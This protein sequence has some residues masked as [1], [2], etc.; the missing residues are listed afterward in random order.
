MLT[1]FGFENPWWS[2]PDTLDRLLDGKRDRAYLPLFLDLV[3]KT[4]V[5]RAVV[6]MGPRRVGKTILLRQTIRALIQD[7]CV[8][9]KA[10]FFAS[11]ENPIYRGWSLDRIL[12]IFMRDR[13]LDRFA[14]FWAVFDEIQ[15]LEEWEAHLKVMVDDYPN[16]R[17]IVSG[18][19]AAALRMKSLESGAGRFTDFLLPPLLFAEYLDF[20]GETEAAEGDIDILNRHFFDYINF[21]GFPEAVLNPAIQGDMAR[22]VAEDI[23]EKALLRD[24]PSL[25]GIDNPNEL[26]RFFASM[27]YNSGQEVSLGE[28]SKETGI[29]KNTVLK[30]FQFL[31]A[32]FLVHRLYRIDEHGQRPR[33]EMGFKVYLTN[34]CLRAAMFSPVH[35]GDDPKVVGAMV[36]TAVMAQVVQSSMIHDCYYARWRDGE[37]DL[38]LVNGT[39]G[40]PLR[41]EEFKWSDRVARDRSVVGNLIS[42]AKRH[43]LRAAVISSK[44]HSETFEIDGIPVLCRP[45]ARLC[46]D[47]SDTARFILDVIGI[48]PRGNDPAH[49]D[50]AKVRERTMRRPAN[51]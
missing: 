18:S 8:D 24:L 36:E 11:L 43:S 10:I 40:K 46:A 3:R 1:R 20:I 29:P 9:P 48:H 35:D 16:L 7:D 28:L 27:A 31:E 15:Y 44:T 19:A 21:G 2:N 41:A 47:H 25:Y 38:V 50:R 34:P 13:G 33:R 12:Q 37:I 30:Y 23:V 45:V 26:Y 39:S 51:G 49:Q 17:I 14:E 22:Y 32:A 42:F 4:E 6:L 5:R